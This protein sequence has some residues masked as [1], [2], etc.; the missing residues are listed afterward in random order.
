MARADDQILTK[1]ATF[2]LDP[3]LIEGAI[4][5]AVQ[6]LRPARDT[7]EAKRESLQTDLRRLDE[8]QDRYVA[9]IA[10]AGEIE[11]LGTAMKTCEHDRRRCQRELASLDSLAQ[12][13]TFD[14][15]KVDRD[16]RKR[17]DE[18]RRCCA[19]RRRSP[20]RS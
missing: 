6:E 18:W 17:L 4:A 2:I 15:R 20:G 5:D 3:E 10:A 9:A 11:A 13:D 12:L 1:M 7:I 16:L 8:K 14:V 19:G